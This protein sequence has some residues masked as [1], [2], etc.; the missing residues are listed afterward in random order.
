MLV[1]DQIPGVNILSPSGVLIINVPLDKDD[2]ENNDKPIV[3]EPNITE[4]SIPVG[5]H[6]STSV[7]LSCDIDD[8]IA[9]QAIVEEAAIQP[10]TKKILYLG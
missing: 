1:L 3:P 8:A 4:S 10:F 9:E 2:N 5:V 7:V 6:P